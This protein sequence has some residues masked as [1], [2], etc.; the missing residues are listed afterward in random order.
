M[1]ATLVIAR[2]KVHVAGQRD[3]DGNFNRRHDGATIRVHKVEFQL[4]FAFVF[5]GERDAQ[6]HGALR[7]NG[8]K[9]ARVDRVERAKQIEFAVIVR[10]C[11]AENRYLNVHAQEG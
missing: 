11:V 2:A 4:T 7:M 9:F 1:T 3:F 5:A 8:G 10:C 6:C